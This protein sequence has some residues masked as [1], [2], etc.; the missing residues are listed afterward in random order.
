MHS[1]IIY[2]YIVFHLN[3]FLNELLNH[4]FVKKIFDIHIPSHN[5]VPT[6][7]T[8]SRCQGFLSERNLLSYLL[9]LKRE[10]T[11]YP[12]PPLFETGCTNH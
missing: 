11:F 12:S 10:K 7:A 5:E 2:R 6:C 3:E 8:I 4:H 9:G 1:D